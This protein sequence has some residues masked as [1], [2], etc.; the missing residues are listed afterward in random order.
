MSQY[1]YIVSLGHFCSPAMEFEKINRRA[2]SLPFDWL[3]TP[4]LSVVIDLINNRFEDFLNEDYMFQFKEYP[5]YYRNKKYNVDFYHDFSPFKRFDSQ[6]Q[7]VA[8]K[9]NRRIERFYTIIKQPTLFVRYITKKDVEYINKNY[10]SI[11]RLIKS[12]NPQNDILFVANN[13]IHLNI[14]TANAVYYVERDLND[15]VARNFLSVN[16]E[17]SQYILNNVEVVATKKDTK[18]KY[19]VLIKKAYKRIRLKLKFVY[20]HNKQFAVSAE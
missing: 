13:D 10:D 8:K 18:N 9:Y 12:F 14:Q 2:F 11:L 4:E 15:A 3:I 17:L 19:L 1:K 5:E 20:R 16:D 6:I 7:E